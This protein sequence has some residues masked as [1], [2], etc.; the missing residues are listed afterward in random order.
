MAGASPT[1]GGYKTVHE[2][3]YSNL[4]LLV[5]KE[6]PF[7]SVT[8]IQALWEQGERHLAFGTG[9]VVFDNGVVTGDVNDGAGIDH[10]SPPF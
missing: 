3:I 6:L 4:N 10:N 8:D 5:I 9:G 1:M 7:Q 2:T